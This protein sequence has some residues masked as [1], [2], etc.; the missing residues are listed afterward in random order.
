MSITL[1]Q[2]S[3]FRAIAQEG[4]LSLAAEKLFLSKPAVSMALAELEKQLDRRLFERHKNRLILNEYG[5]SLLPIAD[6]LL[7]R[8]SEIEKVISEKHGH[9]AKLKVGASDTVGTQVVPSLL[10]AFSELESSRQSLVIDN[11]TIIAD[12]VLAFEL[13]IGLIEGKIDHPA[14]AVTPWLSDEMCV[15][16][17]PS[18]PLGQEKEIAVYD[19]ENSCWI[20]REKGSG[21]REHFIANIAPRLQS[22][23]TRFELSNT[24]AIINCTSE[25]L[26]L[27]YLSRLSVRNALSDGRLI[28]LELPLDL[29]RQYWHIQH[30]DKYPTA[31][32]TL[33]T[34]FCQRWTPSG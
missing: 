19:L 32:M 29:R 8:S 28:A 17:S 31:A 20:L 15:V 13:D 23:S 10:K 21:T 27:A 18:H 34:E 26:G 2:L 6:E 14:L 25:G 4:S 30:K 16:C 7:V 9:Y 33:F 24:E 12:K 1:R 11:S 22:W 3:I 5:K